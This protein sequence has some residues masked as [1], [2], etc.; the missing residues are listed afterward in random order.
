MGEGSSSEVEE[1][2]QEQGGTG[3]LPGASKRSATSEDEEEKSIPSSNRK[4]SHGTKKKLK[5][6]DDHTLSWIPTALANI[7]SVDVH[8]LR[9][10]VF[11]SHPSPKT[12]LS[13]LERIRGAA[14]ALL[15]N[16]DAAISLAKAR[17]SLLQRRN[18][19]EKLMALRRDLA[20]SVQL[21]RVENRKQAA[22][23]KAELLKQKALFEKEKETL[24][25][26]HMVEREALIARYTDELSDLKRQLEE[27]REKSICGVCQ[28]K[29]RD[30]IVL[31]CLHFQYCFSCLLR[32]R[33]ANSN[34]CP[35]CRGPIQGLSMSSYLSSQ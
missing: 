32:H 34:T 29:P 28:E 15:N 25:Y 12:C 35:T 18:V 1:E 2:Q 16:T 7:T 8:M 33:E 24:A 11:A 23:A 19:A 22:E 31:P 14:M 21:S 26:S 6:K 10:D 17:Q 3:L 9:R 30:T 20:Q 13:D 27:E 5:S 4:A